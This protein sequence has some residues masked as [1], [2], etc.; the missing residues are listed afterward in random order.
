MI[1]LRKAFPGQNQGRV[2]WDSIF[3]EDKESAKR[4]V[5]TRVFPGGSY[6]R[7]L[8]GTDNA[9]KRLLEALRS[10]APGGW[11]DNRFEQ[12]N[13]Y[14]GITYTAIHRQNEMLT[15]AEFQVFYKDDNAPDGKR[16]V[17]K[18]D[19]PQ[20]DRFCRPYDLVELLEKP[21]RDD[22][23][24][25]LLSNWN[26]QMDLTGS[27]LTHMVPNKLGTPFELYPI[28]TA[29]AIPQP[30]INEQYPFGYY[31][32]QPVYPYGPFSSYPTPNSS[33]GAAIPAQW[34]IRFKYPHPL[35]RYDGYSPL[36]AFNLHIDEV[37][38]IDRSRFYKMKG[39]IDPSA[40]LNSTDAEGAQALPTEEIERILAEFEVQ[41]GPQ[42]HGKLHI[43]A[44]GW[45]L[46]EWGTRPA[47]MEYQAGWEQLVGFVL[48]GLGIT[49]PAAGMIEDAAYATLF[50]TLKQ[51]YWLTLEPKANRIAQKLTRYLGPFFGD[52]LIIEIRCRP[53]DDHEKKDKDLNTL[54]AGKAL[55][56]NEMRKELGY[57][58]TKEEWGE[59]IAGDPSPNELEQ[60]DQQMQAQQEEMKLQQQQ[61]DQ[62]LSLD[63]QKLEQDRE[64]PMEVTKSRPKTR[65]L[66]QGALGPRMKMFGNKSLYSR[67]REEIGAKNGNGRH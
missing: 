67:I 50:A 55:T 24:G 65:T 54:M 32:I 45:K 20:G 25:D 57:E 4:P 17:T 63:K 60:Q 12:A 19:P 6:G 64:E 31:R 41:Q 51:L 48:G 52:N 37:E 44:P 62:K 61:G 21:N 16:P 11:S 23:F 46:E 43:A 66:G 22:S 18:F 14:K 40:V 5:S 34:M 9:Y 49:K 47:D 15:Q 56:K 58:L 39:S 35:L 36:T 42:N 59:D 7:S 1:K 26:L 10:N 30:V 27:A 38:S 33:V 2:T 8:V 28:P 29:L 13:H 53:I 3:G